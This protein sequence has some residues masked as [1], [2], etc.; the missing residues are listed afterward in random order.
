MNSDIDYARLF[1]RYDANPDRHQIAA[2]TEILRLL[3][4]GD[5]GG[6]TR[7]LDVACGTGNWLAV[8]MQAYASQPVEWHGLDASAEMLGVARVKVPTAQLVIGRAEL[9][10]YGDGG[11]N[12]VSTNFAF[13]HFADK[14]TALKEMIRVLA[15]GG[16]LRMNNMA[17]ERADHWWLYRYF[18]EARA[19][20]RGR[21]WSVDRI[22]AEL[23]G[24]GFTCEVDF[25]LDDRPVRL[26][27][28][29]EEAI[30]RDVSELNL[31]SDQAYSDGLAALAR[32]LAAAPDSEIAPG[33][34]IY[35]LLARKP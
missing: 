4:Q 27:T 15:A 12:L 13:H 19:I 9:L 34:P 11:F 5:S 30:R 23:R 28:K 14:A 24:R 3:K 2:D 26:T 31:I 21:F 35:S 1:D 17:A 33:L 10:P 25:S 6:I 8:Q 22:V 18:P 29:L 32:D 7:I 20:D 16:S